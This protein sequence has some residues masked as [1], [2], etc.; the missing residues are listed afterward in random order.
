MLEHFGETVNIKAYIKQSL[1]P[2]GH[3]MPYQPIKI[4]QWLT[5]RVAIITK[6]TSLLWIQKRTPA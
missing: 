2:A 6:L 5:S 4:Q 3:F 1:E